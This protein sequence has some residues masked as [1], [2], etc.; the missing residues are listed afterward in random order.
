MMNM[1][2]KLQVAQLTYKFGRIHDDSPHNGQKMESPFSILLVDDD[3]A[4]LQLMETVL[5]QSSN[6]YN[7]LT[8]KNAEKAIQLMGSHGVDLVVTDVHMKGLSG[9]D[10]LKWAKK[11]KP[12]TSVIVITGD[13]D[14][15]IS[16]EARNN[17]ADDYL[18][19]P[20][21]VTTFQ[22]AV[23]ACLKNTKGDTVSAA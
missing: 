2:A 4:L 17:G 15:A 19:K 12:D 20:F 7:P 22:K 18:T 9:I 8:V 23:E 11:K 14:P 1:Q 3:P 6:S 16:H 21:S 13:P 5:R 10:L